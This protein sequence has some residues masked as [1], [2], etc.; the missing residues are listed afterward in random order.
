MSK[1]PFL[2]GVALSLSAGVVAQT[3]QVPCSALNL[4]FG[5][6]GDA[7]LRTGVGAPYSLTAT[8]KREMKLSDGNVVSGFTTSHQARDSQG[9]TREEDPAGCGIDRD[10]Q[11]HWQGSITVTDPAAKTYTLWQEGF[12]L[13]RKIATVT[14]AQF[15]R[16]SNPPTMQDEI[17]MAQGMS[18]AYS[19]STQAKHPTQKVEDLGKR[20]IAGLEAS[21]M[22]ITR[23][24]PA[25]MAG[26]TLPLAYVEEKWVSDQYR[27]VLLRIND[28]PLL[29]KSTYEVTSFIPGEP[30]V[31][32]FQPPA[33]Y[34][35]DERTVTQ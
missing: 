8:L 31:S 12:M 20:T 14:H 19:V 13:Q 23:T 16:S 2:I 29:G 15:L 28:D 10:G 30:D 11:P 4:G 9:R 22:R 35:I 32:L 17:R 21:G 34:T 24:S 3:A 18:Q 26:N 27:I 6:Q 1:F 7:V 25:G 33:D 5:G